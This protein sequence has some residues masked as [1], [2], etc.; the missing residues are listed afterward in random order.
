ML[1]YGTSELSSRPQ[2]GAGRDMS[3]T[4]T[5]NKLRLALEVMAADRDTHM[6]A[7]EMRAFLWCA[8]QPG[9]TMAELAARIGVGQSETSRI[10]SRFLRIQRIVVDE[11]GVE[12]RIPGYDLLSAE[13]D[14]YERRRKIVSLTPKGTRLAETLVEVMKKGR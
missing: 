4:R 5:L 13:P 6:N 10:I 12:R 11:D 2:N 3:D 1:N 9:I 7:A 14:P 8:I